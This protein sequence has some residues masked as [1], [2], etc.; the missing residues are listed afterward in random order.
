MD[1]KARLDL[2]VWDE[3]T[4][5]VCNNIVRILRFRPETTRVFVLF[6]CSP[7]KYSNCIYVICGIISACN[8]YRH[9]AVYDTCETRSRRRRID[10]YLLFTLYDCCKT[11]FYTLYA[12]FFYA[13]NLKYCRW[14]MIIQCNRYWLMFMS[15]YVLFS[16]R[17]SFST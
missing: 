7:A 5:I 10:D 6:Y 3:Y 15:M 9:F 16:N 1:K 17:I 4:G 13:H 14:M 2:L 12:I 8:Y 11:M